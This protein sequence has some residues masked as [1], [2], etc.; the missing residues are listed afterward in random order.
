MPEQ[1]TFLSGILF[2][3]M[4]KVVDNK[5]NSHSIAEQLLQTTITIAALISFASRIP[6]VLLVLLRTLSVHRVCHVIPQCMQNMGTPALQGGW[7]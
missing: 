5:L 4:F 1:N 2:E 7:L 6:I 3:S